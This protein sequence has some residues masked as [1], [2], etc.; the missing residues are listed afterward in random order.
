ME[1]GVGLSP[2]TADHHILPGL[3]PEVVAEGRG[4]S[5]L[6]PRPLD[7]KALPIQQDEATYREWLRKGIHVG[8]SSGMARCNRQCCYATVQ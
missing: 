8:A 1:E 5:F 3:V 6:L 4:V 2:L 7:L